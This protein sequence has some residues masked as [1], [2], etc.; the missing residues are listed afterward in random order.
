MDNN[1]LPKNNGTLSKVACAIVFVVFSFV[2]LYC[3]QADLLAM[4]QHVMS[5]GITH[6]DRTVGAVL[7]T[8]VLYIVHITAKRLTRLEGDLYF[9]TFFPSLLLL[10][11]L[12]D[13][14]ED[15]MDSPFSWIWLL[16]LPLVLIAFFAFAIFFRQIGFPS[17]VS[18]KNA[19]C[20]S[21][22]INLISLAL[23]F[24]SVCCIGNTDRIFH[25]RM[26]ME[27]LFCSGKFAES[28]KIGEKSADTDK[29][30]VMLRA[31]ALSRQK[32]LGEHL[33]EY[34]IVGGSS[35]LLPDDTE[36]VRCMLYPESEIFRLLSIRKKGNMGTM[37]YLLYL[38]RNGL[39]R[40]SVTD[41][42]LCGYLLDKNLDAFVLEAKKKYNLASPDLPKHYREALTLYTHLRSNPII[43]YRN[44]VMDVDYSDFQKMER[45]YLNKSERESFI[46]DTYGDTYWFYYFYHPVS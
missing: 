39:A 38:E 27:N 35:S 17:Q 15:F 22:W 4:V 42:L 2:Y 14:K 34:P 6:Y 12:T 3:F 13:I 30:L 24:L 36:G 18:C 7:I 5:G 10:S 29:S 20:K 46:R 41:Y 16:A 31:Y 28:L 21:L 25:Y 32:L 44:E 1:A 11:A 40:R 33:F 19:P 26:R 8:V 23:M 43:V 9:L 37:E 45:Q